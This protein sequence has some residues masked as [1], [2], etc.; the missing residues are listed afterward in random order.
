VA[1]LNVGSGVIQQDVVGGAIGTPT[2]GKLD[3]VGPAPAFQDQH[4]LAILPGFASGD[5]VN[6]IADLV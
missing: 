5:D 4:E 3:Y 2:I 1:S 6:A